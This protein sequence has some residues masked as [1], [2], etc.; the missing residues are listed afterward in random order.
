MNFN[1][2]F[3]LSQ[4]TQPNKK[5]ITFNK[6]GVGFDTESTTIWDYKIV[7]KNKKEIEVPF[8][9]E[10]FCYSY[11]FA[12][13]EKIE[14]F[15]T[16]KQMIDFLKSLSDYCNTNL[17]TKHKIIIWVANMSHEWS[18]IKNYIV[19][20]FE[21]TQFFAVEKRKPLLIEINHSIQ[22]RECIGLFGHSLADISDNWCTKYKKLVGDLEYSKIRTW[23]TPLTRSELQY[24]YND[25]LVLSEMH[26][27]IIDH[28]KN[29][30]NSIVIPYTSTGFLRIKLKES[31]NS[32]TEITEEREI[33]NERHKRK[34]SNNC[35]FIAYKNQRLFPYKE[36]DWTLIREYAFSGGL[37]GSGIDNCGIILNDAFCKD[38][39]SDYPFQLLYH[40]YPNGEIKKHF[41]NF[42]ALH[43]IKLMNIN[44]T[45][46]YNHAT[47]SKHKILNN[48]NT[49]YLQI[50]GLPKNMIVF[51]GKLLKGENLVVFMNEVDYDAYSQIYDIKI[52]KVYCT[53]TFSNFERIPE[54]HKK[55]IIS[56]YLAK[57]ILKDKGLKN[58]PQY[59]DSKSRLNA[60]FGCLATNNTESYDELDDE[61]NFESEKISYKDKKR[62]IFNPFIAFYCT[63]Y[64]R[65]EIMYAIASDPENVIQ[66]DTDSVYGSRKSKKLIEHLEKEN[67]KFLQFFQIH[68]P[69]DKELWDLGQWDND[70][71]YKKFLAL[72]AKKYITED[73]KGVIKETIAGLPKGTLNKKRIKENLALNDFN[74]YEEMQILIKNIFHDKLASIYNDDTEIRTVNIKG[75]EQ[76]VTSYHALCEIDFLLSM[77]IEMIKIINEKRKKK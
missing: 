66:Y 64:A 63:S 61:Y 41:G 29:D 14:H 60:N 1:D 7:K 75:V 27:K 70:G 76:E 11:C 39:V 32:D 20:N 15:R 50:A 40:L 2:F 33:W 42:E 45:A 13:G 65:R 47:L 56:D 35:S 71:K 72:G 3:S 36:E 30:D 37:C 23:N 6:I 26:Q 28:Y 19:Q 18:F 38:K 52:N 77:P 21:I 53:Y 22:F 59:N 57:K 73:E 74:V 54:W 49:K 25:V 58:T 67:A 55:V 8:V 68:Y 51:N 5:G 46:K 62:T 43:Y 4:F 9:K 24:I 69:N 34:F 10:C 12:I 17:T 48:N 44:I 31:L 16:A